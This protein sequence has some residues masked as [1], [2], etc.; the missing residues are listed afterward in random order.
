M[1]GNSVNHNF[2]L[3][4]DLILNT[5]RSVFLTGKAGT[6]KTTFLKYIKEHC[7]KN[8]AIVAPTGVAAINAGGTT[9]HSFFQLPFTPFLPENQRFELNNTGFDK[10]SLMSRIKLNA[11]RRKLIGQLELLIIDEI[12]MVRCDILDAIDTVLKIIRNRPSEPFGG[13]QMLLIGDIFQLSPVVSDSEW[14]ILAQCYKSRYFFDSLV[15]ES[16]PPAI[17]ELTKIYRQSDAL[18]IDVLNQIRHNQLNE[19]GLKTLSSRYNPGFVPPKNEGYIHLTTHNSKADSTNLN[20][21]KNLEGETFQFKALIEGDFNEKAYPADE[22]LELKINAQVMFIKNDSDKSKRYFNGKIG[23]VTKIDT[24]N[25]YV[26]CSNENNIITVKKDIWKN[27]RYSL[28]KQTKQIEEEEIGSFTQFPLRL[29]WA[30]TIHKSQGLTFEKV[31]I[32]AGNAFAAGQVY[33][34]LSRCTSLEGLVLQSL[35]TSK[36]LNTDPHITAF[37][38]LSEVQ[39]VSNHL[40]LEKQQFQF[41]LLHTIFDFQNCY[42]LFKELHHLFISLSEFFSS[43][44]DSWF[45]QLESSL[46]GL[47]NDG[48]KVHPYINRFINSRLLPDQIEE[49]KDMV[50]RG[51]LH[52]NDKLNALITMISQCPALT[53]NKRTAA[54]FN[55]LISELYV[56]IVEKIE[57]LHTCRNGFS[58]LNYQEFRKNFKAPL[59]KVNIYSAASNLNN[60]D[61]STGLYQELKQ[62]RDK[63]CEEKSLPV[64]MVA[65][66]QSLNEMATYLPLTIEGLEQITGF[67]KIK[68]EK[69]AHYFLPV[70]NEYCDANQLTTLIRDKI[71]VKKKETVLKEPKTDTKLISLNLFKSG[72]TVTEIAL[73]RKFT[74]QTIENHLAH[75]IALG[76]IGLDNLVDEEKKELILE[77]LKNHDSLSLTII[78]NNLESYPITYGEIRLVLAFK[79]YIDKNNP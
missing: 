40:F 66:S 9:I 41:S 71:I 36:T 51:S 63:I 69:Y 72:K 12:S 29:A 65:N 7:S 54:Q 21:L 1:S 25:I 74:A 61:L 15:W 31:T 17:I 11:E 6:G 19:I 77:E 53:D 47:K 62:I 37:M 58:V 46:I 26:A 73:E 38:K 23:K 18:F 24:E 20:E 27:I 10:H 68:A 75:Y 28:N 70:I 45:S 2:E 16:Q 43:E 13:I 48:N 42:S 33:V 49:L 59:C 64:Y 79:E 50:K 4:A 60:T 52:F 5:N 22:M 3:A 34:A 55:E 67:G 30:I 32:D 8:T 57:L 35:I 76:E 39:Q 44:S 56:S 78:K 14:A